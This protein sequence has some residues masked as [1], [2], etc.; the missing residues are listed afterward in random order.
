M[1]D[2]YDLAAL[3]DKLSGNGGSRCRIHALILNR[4][5]GRPAEVLT[6]LDEGSMRILPTS[7]QRSRRGS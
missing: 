2:I 6:K 7:G 1:G 4:D 5:D 3:I